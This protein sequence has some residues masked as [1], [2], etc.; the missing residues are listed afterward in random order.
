MVQAEGLLG[1]VV[2]RVL[3]AGVLF[4]IVTLYTYVLFFLIGPIDI[5]VGARGSGETAEASTVAN[6]LGVHGNFFEA[7]GQFLGK[8]VTG[9]L[10]T[11]FYGRREVTEI[12][13]NALPVTASLVFGALVMWLLI[14][15]PIG[16]YSALRPRSLFDR[17]GM[18]F[19]LVGISMHPLWVGYMLSYVFGYKLGWFPRDGYCDVFDAVGPCGGPVQWAY[20]L[21]L[22]WLAFALGFS[23][24]YARMIRNSLLDNLHEDYVR[25]AHAKGLSAWGAVRRHALR[26]SLL[27]IVTLIAMDVGLAFGGAVF[28]ERV[29]GL[30]G[31][32]SLLYNALGRR[33]MPVILGIVLLVTTTVIVFNLI[34]DI[35]YGFL[36]PRVAGGGWRRR[37]AV[38]TKGAA[39]TTA[40]TAPVTSG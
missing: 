33:D 16:I 31:V 34:V 32:G 20:H 19:V 28:I 22:P 21:F 18:V 25:T 30:P 13:W 7:Y 6:S 24:L 15:F 27:P 17:A 39:G 1:F 37:R 11:S 35:V 9:D 26:N 14:A 3:W 10:G 8:V 38:E 40:R 4:L 29:F 2:R 36:D 23:A 5:Q 12:L